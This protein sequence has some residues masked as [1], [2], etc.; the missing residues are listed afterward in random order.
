MSQVSKKPE[1]P[2]RKKNALRYGGGGSSKDAGVVDTMIE[3]AKLREPDIHLDIY[4]PNLL[5]MGSR[6]T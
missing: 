5:E 1:K 6:D 4:L 3:R 2:G